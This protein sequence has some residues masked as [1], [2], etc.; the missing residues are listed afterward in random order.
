MNAP[1]CQ[2]HVATE[3]KLAEAVAPKWLAQA[4][5]EDGE[6]NETA[7]HRAKTRTRKFWKCPLEGCLRVAAYLPT[8]EEEKQMAERTCP[9][10]GAS[11]DAD[12][13]QRAIG[14]TYCRKCLREKQKFIDKNRRDGQ[15]RRRSE[16]TAGLGKGFYAAAKARRLA[17]TH[18]AAA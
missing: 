14:R 13:V 12:S 17:R 9:R 10:C 11:C 4:I 2:L 7:S 3:M 5:G 16:A 8:D 15:R 6:D 18:E 1:H